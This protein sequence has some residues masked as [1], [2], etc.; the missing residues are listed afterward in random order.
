MLRLLIEV[1]ILLQ[2]CLTSSC[3]CVNW[4][5]EDFCPFV[6]NNDKG[7]NRYWSGLFCDYKSQTC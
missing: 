7:K 3:I 5:R 6:T 2:K 1:A 4:I